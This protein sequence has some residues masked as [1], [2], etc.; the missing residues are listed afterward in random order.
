MLG[1][2]GDNDCV[3]NVYPADVVVPY[4]TVGANPLRATLPIGVGNKVGQA[5]LDS[6]LQIG[7]T[8]GENADTESSANDR[9][10]INGLHL[11]LE[12]ASSQW[13]EGGKDTRTSRSLKTFAICMELPGLA[14][15]RDN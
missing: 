14:V 5:G 2:L 9:L 8:N 15:A 3:R 1:F 13:M 11:A 7:R 6:V 12:A 4:M 10:T